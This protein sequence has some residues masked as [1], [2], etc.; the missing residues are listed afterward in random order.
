MTPETPI[1]LRLGV[2]LA[3]AV[4]LDTVVQLLWKSAVA[5]V[6]PGSSLPFTVEAVLEQPMFIVVGA[7]MIVQLLNWLKVLGNADLSYAKPITSLSYVTVSVF[8]VALLGEIIHPLQVVGIL[9]VIAGVWLI[10]QTS[11]SSALEEAERT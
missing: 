7:L 10:S 4:A 6:P 5:D 1:R 3:L 8:S 11:H 2:G 9:I